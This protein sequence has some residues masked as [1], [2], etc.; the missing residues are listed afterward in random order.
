M[1]WINFRRECILRINVCANVR[2]PI[3]Y[4]HKHIASW[5]LLYHSDDGSII[6]RTMLF[7]SM[8][9]TTVT[10]TIAIQPTIQEISNTNYLT[11]HV[12]SAAELCK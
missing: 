9:L 3:S 12:A 4:S 11:H 2:S 6:L 10:N 7:N 8:K 5:T 1:K